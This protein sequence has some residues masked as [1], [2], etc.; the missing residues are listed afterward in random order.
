[1]HF[2]FPH[3]NEEWQCD[4]R[5]DLQSIKIKFCCSRP[6]Y[7][8][9]NHH[10]IDCT[11]RIGA[12]VF[13]R[14][15][16]KI[17]GFHCSRF[18]MW[19]FLD[20]FCCCCWLR[21]FRLPRFHVAY[22]RRTNAQ[23]ANEQTHKQNDRLHSAMYNVNREPPHFRHSQIFWAEI[24]CRGM[25][26]HIRCFYVQWARFAFPPDASHVNY[27]NATE[28]KHKQKYIQN[29]KLINF[30]RKTNLQPIFTFSSNR[31]RRHED[32]IWLWNRLGVYTKEIRCYFYCVYFHCQFV[33][34]VNKLTSHRSASHRARPLVDVPG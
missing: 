6:S 24:F 33:V 14:G 8:N 3:E 17:L 1:M 16:I 30:T 10:K 13:M 34:F 7:T 32:S 22:L 9:G 25:F 4:R 19:F 27:K 12:I 28:K 5:I 20:S 15:E 26:K 31:R 23:Q 29:T 2:H 18:V 11:Y 21:V